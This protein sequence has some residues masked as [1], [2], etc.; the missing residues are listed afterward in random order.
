[1]AYHI[2]MAGNM[3]SGKS[4]LMKVLCERTDFTPYW[5][6]PE[7]RPYTPLFADDPP[8]WALANQIDFLAARA[9]EELA[10]RQAPGVACQ[11]GSLDQ[12][13]HVFTQY[14]YEKGILDLPGYNLCRDLYLLL[15]ELNPTPDLIIYL[16]APT[17]TMAERRWG[18]RRMTD[19]RLV[20]SSD[21]PHLGRLFETWITVIN[22]APV[23]LVDSSIDDP[24]FSSV[25]DSVVDQ[26]Y[27][28]LRHKGIDC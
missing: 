27:A 2:A 20:A 28:N 5:E 18:R 6:V 17:N 21:L 8:R 7:A 22:E 10:L 3:G 24:T 16:T 26:V 11:D 14:F 13:F 9:K 19:E 23:I 12:N 25:I 4:T 1:M 15:R